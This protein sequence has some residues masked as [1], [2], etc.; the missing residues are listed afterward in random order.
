MKW[1]AGVKCAV[2][3]TF[4][5]DAE[6]LWFSRNPKN[7][8][9]VQNR[10]RGAYGPNEAVPRILDMLARNGVKSTFFIPGWVIEQYEGIVRR[11][12]E[13]GHEIGYHGYLHECSTSITYDEENALMEKC[14]GIIKNI[15]GK[16]PVGHRSPMGEILPHTFR[17]LR[18]RGYK[19]SANMM[20]WDSPYFH[21]LE[22]KEIPLVE[23][24]SDWMYEDC[25]Y[26]FFTLQEP[27]RRPILPSSNVFEIWR[28]EFDGLY[29]EG[30]ML[31]IINHPQVCGRVSRVRMM[32]RLIVHMK[33]R[34]GTW[35]A[36]AD[37]IAEY[38]LQQRQGQ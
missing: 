21:R 10:S 9:S 33:S 29:D 20:D 12:S 37:E 3:F 23:I 27:S 34:P 18:D 11:I 13:E 16:K 14:E 22:G 8:D 30:K 28:D 1:P 4:D 26:F 5:L 32:E 17:L 19:Y 6:T 36:R 31:T 7:W 24:P 15:T 38:L 25:T 2:V 35:I